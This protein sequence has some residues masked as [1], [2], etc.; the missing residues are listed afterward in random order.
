MD[1]II[2]CLQISSSQHFPQ[3]FGATRG[4]RFLDYL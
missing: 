1:A 4:F 3:V 2:D